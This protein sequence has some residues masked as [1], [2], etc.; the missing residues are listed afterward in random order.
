[1]K[2]SPISRSLVGALVGG[3]AVLVGTL[4]PW[5]S[6]ATD[7]GLISFS[8]TQAAGDDSLI[9]IG[10]GVLITLVTGVALVRRWSPKDLGVLIL[11]V[12]S[13]SAVISFEWLIT[14]FVDGNDSTG[15]IGAGVWVVILGSVLAT[16][17]GV[18]TLIRSADFSGQRSKAWAGI[19]LSLAAGLVVV[20]AV[21]AV[22][23]VVASGQFSQISPTLD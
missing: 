3:L 18:S 11:M 15:V 20:M 12:G 4:L 5:I 2:D 8:G 9:T 7:S 14:V 13:A 16:A 6:V 21:D 1:M 22:A 23:G 17:A 19:A 10:G